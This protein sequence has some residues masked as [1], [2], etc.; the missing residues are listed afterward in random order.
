MNQI[1]ILRARL[2][3]TQ[4]AMAAGLGVSQA[5]VSL[6]EKGQQVPPDVA[7]RLITYAHELGHAITFNDVYGLPELP[8][9]RKSDRRRR[10]ER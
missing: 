2:G 4:D 1:K 10:G 3:V 5:N 8:Q 9:R 6:Y 7:R